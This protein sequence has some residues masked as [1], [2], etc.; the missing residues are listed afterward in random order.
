MANEPKRHH[1]V[2]R[3]YMRRFSDDNKHV[4]VLFKKN[5]KDRVSQSINIDKLCV[6]SDFYA[7]YNDKQ[8]YMDVENSLAWFE[9]SI[10]N[11]VLSQIDPNLVFPFNEGGVM[12]SER[13]K[14]MVVD[15]IAVQIARGKS[16]REYGLSV[17][18]GHFK[19]LLKDAKEEFKGLPDMKLKMDYLR[20][21][22]EQIKKNAL[23]EGPVIEL[24]K[25]GQKSMMRNNLQNRICFVLVNTTELDFITSDEPVLVCDDSGRR[26]GIFQCPLDN[27]NS[28]VYYPLDP[29]HMIALYTQEYCH[30]TNNTVGHTIVLSDSDY[31]FI[32]SVNSLQF[33]QCNRYAMAKRK[34]SFVDVTKY[35]WRYQNN[36]PIKVI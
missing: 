30:V 23:A 20:K 26:N 25:G 15:A 4:F 21:N 27:W 2:T 24:L 12:L 18:D 28:F 34:E 8:K 13:Q 10:S 36:L 16:T 5:R 31:D 1:Y 3:A 33:A 14:I 29:K 32:R 35:D 9:D 19:E 7:L 17:I 22:E 11:K 6:E